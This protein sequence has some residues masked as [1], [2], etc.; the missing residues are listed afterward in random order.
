MRHLV[1]FTLSIWI[2]L[3]ASIGLGG[4]QASAQ[5]YDFS[6]SGP[7]GDSVAGSFMVNSSEQIIDFHATI[8]WATNTTN[9]AASGMLSLAQA[10]GYFVSLNQFTIDATGPVSGNP[11]QDDTVDLSP[12]GPDYVDDG[13]GHYFASSGTPQVYEQPTPAPVP[14]AGPLSYLVMTIAVMW[15]QR[16]TLLARVGSLLGRLSGLGVRK[17]FPRPARGLPVQRLA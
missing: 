16:K 3:A 12:G 7:T 4:L 6:F 15:F 11:N 8:I 14:G 1:R 2:T 9:P 17:R 10:N 5:T 13:M